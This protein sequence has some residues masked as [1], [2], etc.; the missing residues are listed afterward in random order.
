MWK[1]ETEGQAKAVVIIIHSA[2]EH[3]R[4]YAWLIEKLR[5]EGIHVVMG[6]LPGHGE[7][8]KYLRL[9]NESIIDYLAFIKLLLQNAF[10]YG[11]P[12]FIIGHGFGA[13]LAIEYLR[14]NKTDCAGLILSAPWLSLRKTTKLI[15]N[16]LTGI[17]ALAPN[18]KISLAFEKKLLTRN[19]EGYAE[20]IDDIPY[21]SNV[22]GGWYKDIQQLM[23]NITTE[24]E[25]KLS[26]PVLSLM[27][28][29]DKITDPFVVKKW[30][31]TQN[32]VE[33][34]YKE[35]PYSY[36][37]LFHDNERE[38]VFLYTRDFINNVMR[39]LGYIVK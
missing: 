32:S 29:Q 15:P 5:G 9:H 34:Q 21:H 28:Q 26:L 16:A 6:D 3:H 17:G 4:W 35:W 31:Y 11:L 36:H 13:T 30:L 8:S 14:K 1:W 33:L 27:A 37:N 10:H 20:I 7:E 18:K 25:S 23:K 38:E 19:M 39:S 2:F 12:V 24:Q 22:T